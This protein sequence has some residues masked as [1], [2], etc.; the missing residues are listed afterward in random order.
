MSRRAIKRDKRKRVKIK[1]RHFIALSIV[2]YLVFLSSFL[3]IDYY[4]NGILGAKVDFGLPI[5]LGIIAA[6]FHA[7]ARA[8]TQADVV[9]K[10][11]EEII[12]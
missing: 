5:I 7:K 2:Y 6:Y 3:L 4:A 10:E 12:D 8:K 9:A 11:I 1:K